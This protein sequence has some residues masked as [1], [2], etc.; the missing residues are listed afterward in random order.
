MHAGYTPEK[1]A[2]GNEKW[3]VGDEKVWKEGLRDVDAGVY[4]HAHR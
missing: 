4:A 1:D 3:P 2:Q